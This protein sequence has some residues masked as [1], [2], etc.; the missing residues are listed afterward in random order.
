MNAPSSIPT[1]A[2]PT[3]FYQNRSGTQFGESCS[4]I[5]VS[6]GNRCKELQPE[7][8]DGTLEPMESEE[9][10]TM[11]T[12]ARKDPVPGEEDAVEGIEGGP[13]HI[14][15]ADGCGK[16]CI[17]PAPR[18]TYWTAMATQDLQANSHS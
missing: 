2:S 12:F 4:C 8:A 13:L 10:T 7:E 3:E 9:N 18:K 6:S 15:G 5:L 16:E 11:G 1:A 14:T 17:Q